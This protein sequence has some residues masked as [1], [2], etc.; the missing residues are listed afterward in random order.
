MYSLKVL[1]ELYHPDGRIFMPGHD[2]NALDAFEV[3]EL[4]VNYPGHFEA[5]D[6]LSA[7][8]VADT[9]KMERFAAAVEQKRKEQGELK[10]RKK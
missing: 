10:A 3:A 5:G 1:K 2:C 8:L 7:A 4:V 9:G 6:L